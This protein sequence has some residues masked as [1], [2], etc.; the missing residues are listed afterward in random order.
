MAKSQLDRE[1]KNGVTVLLSDTQLS[2]RSVLTYKSLL[3]KV[4]MSLIDYKGLTHFHP[5]L[6][7]DMAED[8][9]EFV[10]SMKEVR[11]RATT[12][13][14]LLKIT[15]LDVYKEKVQTLREI[16]DD[17]YGEQQLTEARSQL[18]GAS[19]E[20]IRKVHADSLRK[21]PLN[22][23]DV[24]ITGIFSGFYDELPPRRLQEWC[25]VKTSNYDPDVDNYYAH[26]AVVFNKHKNRDRGRGGGAGAYVLALPEELTPYIERSIATSCS[27][28]L[29]TSTRGNPLDSSSLNRRLNTYFGFSVD[30]LRSVYITDKNKDMPALK[31]MEELAKK[32]GHN[33]S[34]QIRIYT[35]KQKVA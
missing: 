20:C 24:V 23:M 8:C 22:L 18:P 19:V 25:D 13:S 2:K 28:Y 29:L 31:D 30:V 10:D 32:M 33:V 35:K 5:S 1:I 15:G 4:A 21:N 27:E 7:T 17:V 12:Y 6:F 34:T 3:F 16:I 14:A 9:V 11:S 26:G